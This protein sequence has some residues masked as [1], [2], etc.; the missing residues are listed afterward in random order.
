MEIYAPLA[1]R[2]GM[3]SIREDLEDLAFRVLNAD[4]RASI[5]RRFIILQKETGDV[6]QRITDDMHSELEVSGIQAK[7]S[8]VEQRSPILFGAKCRRKP[9]RFLAY[10]ISMASESYAELMKNVTG[11]LE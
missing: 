2:M 9:Y 7:K 8:R 3:Q 11:Y 1:G 6:V 4:G 10:R 5:I